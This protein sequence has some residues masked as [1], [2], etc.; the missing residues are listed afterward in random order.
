ME[1]WRVAVSSAISIEAWALRVTSIAVMDREYSHVVFEMDCLEL[2]SCF[3]DPTPPC[4]RKISALVEDLKNWAV[5]RKV[6]FLPG[7]I[8]PDLDELLV[9]DV[10]S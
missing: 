7:C 4:P 1:G 6:L 9:R 3:K 2:I 5:N 8:L 10:I